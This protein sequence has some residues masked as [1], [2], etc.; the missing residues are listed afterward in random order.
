M[1]KEFQEFLKNKGILSQRS[2]PY[3]PQ[4][5]RV[6]ERKNCHLLDI[7]YT[8]LIDSLVPTWFWVEALSTA[9]HLI[10][11]LP[12]YVLNFAS[13]YSIL[14]GVIPEYDSLHVFG[15][16]CFVHLPSTERNKLST[17]A[18][19]CAFLGYSNSHKGFVCYDANAHKIR[20][21][22]NV[23]FFDNHNFFPSCPPKEST[24]I[25]LPTFDDGGTS[26]VF[27]RFKPGIVYQRRHP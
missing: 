5:N 10:N 15:C 9:V 3:T 25:Q 7:V 4:Q 20:I 11:R 17:Q 16:V 22:R 23:I 14:F 21:S 24:P 6:V 2:C 12:S 18:A 19:R 26:Y 27:E 8:L 13:P 1:S